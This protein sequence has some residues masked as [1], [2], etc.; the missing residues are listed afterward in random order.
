MSS[1]IANMIVRTM[2]ME[3]AM[4]KA[5]CAM[6]DRTAGDQTGG[7]KLH[8]QRARRHPNIAS[9]PIRTPSNTSTSR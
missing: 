5:A 9:K 2:G 7:A 3:T 4:A 6:R 8:G 1:G